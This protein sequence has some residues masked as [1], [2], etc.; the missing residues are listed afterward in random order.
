M[1]VILI[2][3][4]TKPPKY[5]NTYIHKSSLYWL[6]CC[7]KWLFWLSIK[8]RHVPLLLNVKK[9]KTKKMFTTICFVLFEMMQ[10]MIISPDPVSYPTQVWYGVCG[11]RGIKMAALHSDLDE[12]LC[13]QGEGR[14]PRVHPG[15]VCPIRGWRIELYP[16]EVHTEHQ[17]GKGVIWKYFFGSLNLKNF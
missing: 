12:Q 1:R 13:W 17:P 8:E 4:L 14:N 2:K 11:P 9:D 15:S 16:Q 10:C 6:K 5:N 7:Y 3:I